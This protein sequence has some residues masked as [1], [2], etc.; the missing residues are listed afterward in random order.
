MLEGLGG[1]IILVLDIWAIISIIGSAAST[2]K[3]VLWVLL[4]LILPVIGFI[5][6]LVAGPRSGQKIA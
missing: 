4:V 2:G 5:I 6:W 3:K 1:L